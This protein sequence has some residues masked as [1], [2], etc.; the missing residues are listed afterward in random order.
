[1]NLQQRVKTCSQLFHVLSDETRIKLL[2][3]LKDGESHVTDLCKKL[4]PPQPTVSHHLALLRVHGLV[5]N[6]RAGK[7]PREMLFCR[8]AW[9]DNRNGSCRR[10]RRNAHER[11]NESAS[12]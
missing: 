2:L 6:R 7:R 3:V 5:L 11:G 10:V 8:S 12:A 9:M 1:M 4:K